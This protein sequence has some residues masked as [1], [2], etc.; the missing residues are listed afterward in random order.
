MAVPRGTF[1]VDALQNLLT[2]LCASP[3]AVDRLERLEPWAVARV[4]LRSAS[5]LPCSVVVKW[6][7]DGQREARSAA[8]RLRNELA[9]L[10]FLTEDLGIDLA[11]RV[12]A[13]DTAAR[14]VVLE[15]LAPRVPLDQLLRRDGAEAH[16]DRLAAFA[17][18]RGALSAATSGRAETYY[19]RRAELGPV[20]PAADRAGRLAPLRAGAIEHAS[21]L[22][23]P[24]GGRSAHELTSALDELAAPG[25]FLALSNGDTEANNIL[26]HASGPAEARLIDFEFAGYTHALTDAVCLYVPG[27]AWL[28][29]GDPTT[30]GLAD[31]YRRALARG[32][33][34]A[35]DDRRYG[36]GLA[37]ACVS[38]TLIRL[39][40]FA[41]LD[42][43]PPGDHSRLQLI[44]TLETA[45]GTAQTC[46][47]LPHLTSW[48]RRIAAVLRHRWPDADQDF[49]DPTR[50]PPYRAR[51]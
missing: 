9:A 36:H 44:A 2:D 28:A 39:R 42:T 33:P 25:P 29:V 11:P 20:D 26:L 1:R 7:P 18:A 19:A 30:T 38:W 40:R 24:L 17:R 41:L 16:G 15:D 35:E 10:Q 3:V 50:F 22:G 23:V 48:I 21:S 49:A 14:F 6:I 12:I 8:W 27:P 5:A 46:R 4:R 43:R 32:I 37:A 51:H 13:A 31:Q 47:T 45:A 34:E